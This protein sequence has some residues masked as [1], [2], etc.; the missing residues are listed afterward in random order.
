MFQSILHFDES[1][2]MVRL[3]GDDHMIIVTNLHYRSKVRFV[4]KKLNTFIQQGCIEMIFLNA[5]KIVFQ[6][7]IS[8]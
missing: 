6:Q 1:K 7:L 5:K 4:F 8:K 3:C 2:K